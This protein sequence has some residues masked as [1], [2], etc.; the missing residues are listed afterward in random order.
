LFSNC[1][2]GC[3]HNI[4]GRLAK[5]AN[6]ADAEPNRRT[7]ATFPKTLGIV[8]ENMLKKKTNWI[9]NDFFD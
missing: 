7:A 6:G 5:N 1:L 2:C 4:D 3:Y 8:S 9:S